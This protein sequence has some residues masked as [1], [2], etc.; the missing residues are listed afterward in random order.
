[1]GEVK[2][3]K[4]RLNISSVSEVMEQLELFYAA[5]IVNWDD[6]T[7]KLFSGVY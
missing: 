6:H 2:N 5:G 4:E 3:K 1:M 7:G